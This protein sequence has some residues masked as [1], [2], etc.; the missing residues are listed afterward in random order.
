MALRWAG[1]A[2]H[3]RVHPPLLVVLPLPPPA[4][5]LLVRLEQLLEDL[6]GAVLQG[7]TGRTGGTGNS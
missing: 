7:G 6:V 4:Q 2:V 1:I 5:L 3:P